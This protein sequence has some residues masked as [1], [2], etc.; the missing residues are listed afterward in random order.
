MM[1]YY[2]RGEAAGK[3]LSLKCAEKYFSYYYPVIARYIPTGRLYNYDPTSQ[4]SLF[5]SNN[6]SGAV[7]SVHV[8]ID[9]DIKCQM[10]F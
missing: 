6:L 4:V 7:K 3:F 9:F 1:W 8:R 5:R 10:Q 2:Y